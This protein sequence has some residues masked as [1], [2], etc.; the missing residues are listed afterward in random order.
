MLKRRVLISICY[1]L[2]CGFNVVCGQTVAFDTGDITALNEQPESYDKV[3]V[4][5]VIINLGD[6][7]HQLKGLRECIRVLRP[8]GVLLLSE[9]TLQGWQQMNRFRQEWGLPIIPMPSFNQYL[10]QEKV[11]EA[12][13]PDLQL[14]EITNFSS[15][16][17]VGTRVLKPLLIQALGT[18]VDVANPDMEWNRWFAQLPPWGDYGVQKLLVFRKDG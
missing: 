16:Y 11:I 8:G 3:V 6:W 13:S 1:V 15:T 2:A 9:A 7:I 17:Y 10:D 4:V 18:K 5:R 12:V 14:I